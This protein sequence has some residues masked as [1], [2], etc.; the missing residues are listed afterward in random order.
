MNGENGSHYGSRAV[1]ALSMCRMITNKRRPGCKL[2]NYFWNVFS[3][4]D[5]AFDNVEQSTAEVLYPG[6]WEKYKSNSMNFLHLQAFG[7]TELSSTWC[8]VLKKRKSFWSSW[9]FK[10]WKFLSGFLIFDFSGNFR[11]KFY[12]KLP[13]IC[14][15][16][17][18]MGMSLKILDIVSA[19]EIHT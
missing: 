6:F 19:R 3:S 5:L 10:G 18:L 12:E 13:I 11:T 15:L 17:F 7:S 4:A 9:H 8:R 16:N 2:R 1:T 14:F